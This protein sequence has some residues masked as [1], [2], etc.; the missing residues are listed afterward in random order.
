MNVR[1]YLLDTAEWKWDE[2]LH[3]WKWILPPEFA[4][5]IVNR[6]GDV[7]MELGDGTIQHLDIGAGTLTQVGAN[8]DAFCDLLDDPEQANFFLMIPLVDALASSR[9][10]LALEQCYSFQ[11]AP[12]FSE[13]GYSLDNIVV[14]PIAEHYH[15]FGPIHELTRDV[16]DGA[17]VRFV[18]TQDS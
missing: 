14:R 9:R 1:D 16:P 10:E 17:R 18:T 15:I 4:V 5:R 3:R 7:F 12:A 11:T 6:F 8:W 2:L 13:G